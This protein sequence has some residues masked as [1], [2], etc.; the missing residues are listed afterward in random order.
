MDPS[1]IRLEDDRFGLIGLS[2]RP[3]NRATFMG[4]D[5]DDFVWAVG[6]VV[7]D[8]DEIQT[9]EID[10]HGAK[11]SRMLTPGELFE[12]LEILA[13]AGEPAH[14]IAGTITLL[15]MELRA[16]NGT[17]AHEFSGL[18]RE[19]AD[20][21]NWR[22]P[23]HLVGQPR[24]LQLSAQGREILRQTATSIEQEGHARTSL[25]A[26]SRLELSS[27]A[28]DSIRR[29]VSRKSLQ[30]YRMHGRW[31][32]VL[33]NLA[34]PRSS[35][36]NGTSTADV[37]STSATSEPLSPFEEAPEETQVEQQY[38]VATEIAVEE[39]F[40][41]PS[42]PPASEE[43]IHLQDE[44]PE[45]ASRAAE[46]E[47]SQAVPTEHD[48][49]A[50]V[51]VE[52]EPA[53]EP[54]T[55]ELPVADAQPMEESPDIEPEPAI[56]VE[57]ATEQQADEETHVELE[58]AE[59]ELRIT[60]AEEQPVHSLNH[61]DQFISESVL[62][63]FLMA[64]SE[65]VITPPTPAETAPE[66]SEQ[67]EADLVSEEPAGETA[68]HVEESVPEAEPESATEEGLDASI[69]APSDVEE[70]EPVV[71]EWTRP[72]SVPDEVETDLTDEA[73][74]PVAETHEE[75]SD[76]LQAAAPD[77]ADEAEVLNQDVPSSEA[78]MFD[79]EH[80][81]LE[82]V[83]PTEEPEATAE[84]E[85]ADGPV[86]PVAI[87]EPVAAEEP[88]APLETVAADESEAALETVAADESEGISEPVAA[89]EAQAL[90]EPV[91]A[92]QVP[93][94]HVVLAEAEDAEA[95][96]EPSEF[97]ATNEP[98]EEIEPAP[99]VA[100]ESEVIEAEPDDE[101]APEQAEDIEVAAEAE[102]GQET[103]EEAPERQAEPE[104]EEAFSS[105][106]F[107][108][109]DLNLLMHLRDEVDF[110]RQQGQEKD[111]QIV[112]WINGAQWLQPFVD[113]I[114]SL[115]HQVERLGELQAS[116]DGDRISDL[117]S[118]RDL[119]RQ[120]LDSLETEIMNA[121]A[122]SNAADTKGRSWFRRMM[123]PD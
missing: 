50:F 59:T 86:A 82:P 42:E 53:S 8:E 13:V 85:T 38:A 105:T 66:S 41:A 96:E 18:L 121:R 4:R 31:Y 117:M 15:G 6:I 87:S 78:D 61:V 32:V 63:Q 19:A 9:V 33:D 23:L 11:S 112:A 40:A 111:R 46:A 7:G 98:A 60:E 110:L 52:A 74:A 80:V 28:L 83:Q 39:P 58:P 94:E 104:A 26:S 92:A 27:Q 57:T 120:R 47:E 89:E 75:P 16:N 1:R 79:E 97:E 29:R 37:P 68:E 62:D 3:Q 10:Q 100:D 51:A 36:L 116:R 25:S 56:S 95:L 71:A 34:R 70:V 43:T 122:A 93:E 107:V 91:D 17:T 77:V 21:R 2:F 109:P 73:V 45:P 113:Q 64:S 49:A 99:L 30:A 5:G 14:V 90:Q 24:D 101:Q 55:Q 103:Y 48:L 22:L 72:E 12:G 118:E 114:R 20:D 123:G 67:A 108:G 54:I 119:L 106:G 102:S 35:E 88:E 65:T 81:E 76:E 115:E 44:Q 84:P 69:D